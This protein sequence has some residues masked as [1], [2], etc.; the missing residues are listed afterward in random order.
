M[1]QLSIRGDNP[2]LQISHAGRR[3]KQLLRSHPQLGAERESHVLRESH[4]ERSASFLTKSR[5]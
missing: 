3:L 5:V 4:A 2:S 1:L